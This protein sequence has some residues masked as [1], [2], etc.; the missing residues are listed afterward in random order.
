MLVALALAGGAA[1]AAAP[2]SADPAAA[3]AHLL[4]GATAFREGRFA[5]ALVEFRVAERL[6]DPDAPAYAG[7]VLV[8]LGRPEEAVEAFGPAPAEGE[9][10]LLLWYR[11]L[12]L[13]GAGLLASADAALAELGDRAGPRV[14]GEAAKVRAEIAGALGPAGPS[15]AAVDAALA[16]AAVLRDAGRTALAAASFREAAALAA[17]RPDRHRLAEA[18]RAAVELEAGHAPALLPP[19]EGA[20]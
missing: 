2:P 17:R 3:A 15:A 1:P 12:A 6:G 5:E 19:T 14:G 11:A 4:A 7:A 9:D 13:R 20:P 10:V 18:A 16:R 8:K